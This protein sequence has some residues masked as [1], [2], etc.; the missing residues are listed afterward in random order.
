MIERNDPIS[1]GPCI[2]CQREGVSFSVSGPLWNKVTH[3]PPQGGVLCVECFSQ[4]AKAKGIY[5]RSWITV[6][7]QSEWDHV[8]PLAIAGEIVEAF[9]KAHVPKSFA[10]LHAL[11]DELEAAFLKLKGSQND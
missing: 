6:E 3:L 9:K 5:L 7:A 2:D 8:H 4:R 1:D 10:K 11:M